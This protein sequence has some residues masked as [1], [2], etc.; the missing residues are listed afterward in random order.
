LI[1][2]GKTLLKAQSNGESKPVQLVAGTPVPI[3]LDYEEEH[4]DAFIRL[5]WK[6]PG[7]A[8]EPL[9]ARVLI[10]VREGNH[11]SV[12]AE[13]KAIDPRG[14]Q[15]K[16][17]LSVGRRGRSLELDGAAIP[18][19]YE[20]TVPDQLQSEIEEFDTR[21]VP[22]VV[23]RDVQESRMT[24]MT[25]EDRELIR[26]NIDLVEARNVSDLLAILD[27][28][29]FG[30]ELWKFLAVAAFLLLLLEVALARWISKSRRAAEDVKVEFE[31]RGG[32]DAAFLEKMDKLKRVG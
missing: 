1:L 28:K 21:E 22:L 16:M 32:P 25:D 23:R 13:S 11:S 24:S 10:P 5:F 3:S 9:P 12:I 7:G 15:R 30:Q 6:T 17:S 8:E 26:N 19:L 4:G 14:V 27:G 18:G 29:G 2:D 20:L 31:E